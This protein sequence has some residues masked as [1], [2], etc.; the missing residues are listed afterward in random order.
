MTSTL[1]GRS[2]LDGLEPA[3]ESP[4]DAPASTP[5]EGL[6]RLRIL[7]AGAM[8]TVLVSYALL[9]PAAAL[10]VLTAGAGI[11]FDGAFAAA[12]PLWLAAHQIPLVLQ[13]QP[14]SVLPL[15]PTGLV[16]GVVLL[17]SGW[18]VRR[19]GGRF[20]ADAGAV[21]ATV[22]GA[23]A[24]VAV[25]GSALLPSAAEVS[26]APWAAMIGGALVAGVAAALGVTRVCGLPAEWSD[27]V[28]GWAWTGLRAAGVAVTALLA[29][30][31][32][33]L[34]AALVLGAPSVAGAYRLLAPGF[35]AG[36][37]L[38]LLALAYLPNAVIAGASWVLGPGVAVGTATASPFA[39]FPGPA[40]HFPLLAALP[41]STP[42]AWVLA[43]LALPVAAGALAGL[44]CRRSDGAARLPAAITATVLTAVAFGLLALLAGGRLAAGAFDPIRVPAGLVLPA[45]LLLVG[46]PAVVVAAVQRR[47][48]DD[49][50]DDGP[51]GD[52][53]AEP[54]PSAGGSDRPAAVRARAARA[55]RRASAAGSAPSD[56]A[57]AGSADEDVADPEGVPDGA[58]AGG[59]DGAA[60]S[61]A[62]ATDTGTAT[63]ADADEETDADADE[64]TDTGTGTDTDA[65]VDRGDEVADAGTGDHRADGD[66]GPGGRGGNESDADRADHLVGSDTV[67]DRPARPAGDVGAAVGRAGRPWGVEEG[68]PVPRTVAEL[69]AMRARQAKG[70]AAAPQPDNGGAHGRS[71]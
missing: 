62:E 19:L 69:V 51:D 50:P 41:T 40:S 32:L 6:D 18:A 46:V 14:L 56:G 2:T 53:E 25:L 60:T 20:R 70:S 9:V 34:L 27:R 42:P 68:E 29:A 13:G 65:V 71:Q 64:E 35:G 21:L 61:E 37:G 44:V 45:V 36:L 43:V 3:A 58:A 5:V 54:D 55:R 63:D 48:D 52:A 16:F 22:A 39:A 33:A 17:G 4:D 28:P 49:G 31:A 8:G 47:A 11:S 23:H 12:I 1:D 38:T 66:A 26:A 67:E 59:S 10:V 57:P 24:A 15:L 7:L 30:G